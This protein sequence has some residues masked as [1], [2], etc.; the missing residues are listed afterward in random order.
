MVSKMKILITGAIGLLGHRVVEHCLEE[1][2]EIQA[3]DVS[4]PTNTRKDGV[5]LLKL[6][7]TDLESTISTVNKTKPDAV[8]NTAAITNVD[9]CEDEKEV[10]WK[11][12]VEGARNVAE[13]CK[14]SGAHLIHLSTS[15]VFDGEKGLYSEEDEPNPLGYYGLTKLKG[16]EAIKSVTSDYCIC[17]TDVIFGWGR[18]ERLDF[19]SWVITNLEKKQSVR[20]VTDQINSP[21][22]NTNLAEMVV[23]VAEKHVKGILNTAG[24]TRISR[25]DFAKKI[26]AIFQLDEK[27]IQS[28]K[29]EE[30][31]WKA[32]RPKDA[33]VNI[34]KAKRILSHKPLSIEDALKIMK[35]ER[36]TFETR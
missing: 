14:K 28:V 3:T 13:A 16:E 30:F 20:V 12:N 9:Q 2:I 17:R 26:S 34:S 35:K 22:L 31:S 33:S 6:D 10:A 25:F 19:A 32:R 4:V 8:I 1:G 21:T 11:V 27:Y 18:Q 36:E 15:Y 24:A 23:D 7:I 5:P 29:S